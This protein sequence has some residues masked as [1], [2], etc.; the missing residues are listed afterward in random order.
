LTITTVLQD[1]VFRYLVIF[2]VAATTIFLVLFTILTK[3]RAWR[4]PIGRALMITDLFVLGQTMPF[5]IAAFWMMHGTVNLVAGWTWIGF[6][7]LIGLAYLWLA[8]VFFREN[9]SKI[10]GVPT[11]E[12]Q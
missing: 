2:A 4:D 11:K 7:G 12:Q 3:G 8:I 10:N 1:E 6:E 9:G 5:L